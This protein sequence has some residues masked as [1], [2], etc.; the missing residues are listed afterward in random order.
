M[1]L[2]AVMDTNV[3]Y[4]AF[5]SRLGASFEV[6]R[7]LRLGEWTAMVS[8]H[9]VHEYEEI[10]K[11]NASELG[12]SLEDVDELLNAICARAEEWQLQPGWWPILSDPDDEPLVQLACESAANRIVTHNVR[13]LAPAASVGIEVLKPGQFLATL[14]AT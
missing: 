2:R 9:L 5:R 13:H 3:L 7:R 12:L 10:L 11:A 14:R 6:F 8:N 4:A 1:P